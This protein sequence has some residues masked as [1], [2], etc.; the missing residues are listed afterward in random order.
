MRVSRLLGQTGQV[1]KPLRVSLPSS[2]A[3]FLPHWN[4]PV[5]V[6][7]RSFPT[8]GLAHLVPVAWKGNLLLYPSRPTSQE[9]PLEASLT[10]PGRDS[11]LP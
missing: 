8:L 9:C 6:S 1:P 5:S 2:H 10:P 7:A 3:P 4:L 11:H